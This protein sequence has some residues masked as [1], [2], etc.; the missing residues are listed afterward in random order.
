MQRVFVD[1]AR[2]VPDEGQDAGEAARLE[3]RSGLA[4]ANEFENLAGKNMIE[5]LGTLKAFIFQI[6]ALITRAR[7]AFM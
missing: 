2:V 4:S 5:I 3:H 1:D 7:T 6:S